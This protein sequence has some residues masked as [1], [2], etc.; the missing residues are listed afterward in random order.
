MTA[1]VAV[2]LTFGF[3]Y[4]SFRFVEVPFRAAPPRGRSVTTLLTLWR[5]GGL[6]LI[7]PSLNASIGPRYTPEQLRYAPLDEICHGKI[8]GNCLRGARASET[9]WLLLGDSHAAQLNLFF[10]VVGKANN[11]KV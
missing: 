8:V 10:D 2:I 6:T 1:V 5:S 4:L 7:G 11:V 3:S 9:E